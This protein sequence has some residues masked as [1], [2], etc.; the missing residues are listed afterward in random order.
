MIDLDD[1]RLSAAG[2]GKGRLQRIVLQL[3][4]DH[5]EAGEIPTNGRFVFY[6]LEQRGQVRK[7]KKGESRRGTAVDPREQELIDALAALRDRGIV[8]WEWIADETRELHRYSG[9]TYSEILAAVK[10]DPW[11]GRPPLILVESRSLG[12]VLSRIA[13]QYRCDLAPTNGQVGGFLHTAV[14]P[15]LRGNDRPVLYLGDWDHQGHQIEA[16]TRRV[17]ER[18]TGREIEWERIAITE[19]QIAERNL[20]PAW[21]IDNRYRPPRESLAWEAEALGQRMIM[22]LVREAL[23]AQLP[24]PFTDV[25]EREERERERLTA[26]IE[27]LQ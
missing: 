20:E 11:Q 25:L 23:D 12:G 24:E 2:T 22:N 3:L 18:A 6:E 19:E 16:N 5:Q 1:R 21:K 8:P 9:E 4:L 14:A 27:H 10:I 13:Y 7:S 15:A 17:L 26:L